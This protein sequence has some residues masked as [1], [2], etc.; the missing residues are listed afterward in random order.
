MKDGHYHSILRIASLTLALIL[1][2]DSGLLNPVTKQLSQNAQQYVATA[3]GMSA[4]VEPTELNML[5]AAI[6]Q[7]ERELAE[8][9]AAV[10]A[11]EIAVN[12][13]TESAQRENNST[14]VLSILLFITI[15]LM[16]LNYVLD[17]MRVRT[18]VR[19]KESH[20]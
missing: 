3:V 9:E 5:T 20:A 16:V 4:G 6:T 15:V 19:A 2:F 12:L 13:N 11:R 10:E 18:P 17:Y 14:F 7:K 8:R 1:L